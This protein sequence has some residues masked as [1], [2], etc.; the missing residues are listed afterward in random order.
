M[1]DTPLGYDSGLQVE[2]TLLSWRRTGLSIMGGSLV[3]GRLMSE[4][5]GWWGIVVAI[6]GF[7]SAVLVFGSSHT[8]HKL[9]RSRLASGYLAACPDT[10]ELMVPGAGILAIIAA[11]ATIA[12][13][14]LF[15]TLILSFPR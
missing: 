2:R 15:A 5:Y 8:R 6:V 12:G 1:N 7:I 4:Q 13:L 9:I 3:A 10:N 14:L 11:I